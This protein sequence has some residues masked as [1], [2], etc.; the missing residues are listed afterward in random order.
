MAQQPFN[1]RAAIT[2]LNHD[3]TSSVIH[4]NN[5]DSRAVIPQQDMAAPIHWTSVTMNSETSG[6][7]Q[8]IIYPKPLT[9]DS[10]A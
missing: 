2:Q 1:L 10:G 9:C 8:Y 5:P 3:T 7:P 4:S 6:T